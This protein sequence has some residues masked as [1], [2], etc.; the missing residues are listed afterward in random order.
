MASFDT[1]NKWVMSPEAYK[2]RY[3]YYPSHDL[4]TAWESG[5]QLGP[6]KSGFQRFLNIGERVGEHIEAGLGLLMDEPE[7][8]SVFDRHPLVENIEALTEGN[9]S[10]LRFPMAVPPGPVMTAAGRKALGFLTTLLAPATGP[11]TALVEEPVSDKLR[12]DADVSEGTA[13][14]LGLAATGMIP[15]YGLTRISTV[16]KAAKALART[17]KGQKSNK[18]SDVEVDRW[19]N[20]D[21]LTTSG[22]PMVWGYTDIPEGT[23]AAVRLNLEATDRLGKGAQ[24]QAIHVWDE[25]TQSVNRIG[26]HIGHSNAVPLTNIEFTVHQ[27]TRIAIAQ[28]KNKSK[29]AAVVGDV[30]HYSPAKISRIKNSADV[31]V[32][33]NPRG[34]NMFID[35]SNGMPVKS[36]DIAISE[37]KA[38]YLKGNVQ[39][40]TADE[41]GGGRFFPGN[42]LDVTRAQNRPTGFYNAPGV[43]PVKTRE[44][45][46]VITSRGDRPVVGQFE[47]ELFDL[48]QAFRD[49][50]QFAIPHNVH[51]SPDL[52]KEYERKWA[53]VSKPDNVR[54]VVEAFDRGAKAGGLSWYNTEPLRL[55]FIEEFGPEIGNNQFS[56]F[57]G[58][59]AAASSQT[60]VKEDIRIAMEVYGRMARAQQSGSTVSF[61]GVKMLLQKTHGNTMRDVINASDVSPGSGYFADPYGKYPRT[62]TNRFHQNLLGNLFPITVDTHNVRML[63]DLPK[64]RP[65]PL[66]DMRYRYA[67]LPQQ[68]IAEQ[69]GVPGA[70]YQ[71]A[72]WVGGETGVV[73]AR[74]F[75]QLMEERIKFNAGVSGMKPNIWFKKWLRGDIP[76][77]Y[78]MGPF[79]MLGGGLVIADELFEEPEDGT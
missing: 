56:R 7:E 10:D 61:A 14:L 44:G 78:S 74:P 46:D 75:L 35:L 49:Y 48:R 72:T 45:Y 6:E 42:T 20:L 25:T 3:G 58:L 28:G 16:G 53:F 67:E 38:V 26:Q 2:E 39:Y 66:D 21:L 27:P 62:K 57:M 31:V 79:T 77:V 29:A 24:L 64:G 22:K 60:T 63:T 51:K 50:P 15:G 54:R 4:M 37:G 55:R 70:M 59:V 18:Y 73:D 34:G 41:L 32:G 13:D 43:F 30:T 40:Y 47:S 1:Q 68:E 12:L 19:S 23:R 71:S 76:A 5:P 52:I 8:K 36:A 33:M 69:L 65:T 17:R 11:A 9:R